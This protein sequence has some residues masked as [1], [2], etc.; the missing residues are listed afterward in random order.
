MKRLLTFLRTTNLL[1]ICCGLVVGCSYLHASDI[2]LLWDSSPTPDVTYRLYASTNGLASLT[3]AQVKVNTGTNCTVIIADMQ[4]AVWTFAAT[5]VKQTLSTNP[6]PLLVGQPSV[7]T[8][9]VESAPSN[10]L[11]LEMP[12]PPANTRTYILELEVTADLTSTNWARLGAFRIAIPK[13][14]TIE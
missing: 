3:N 6:V 13:P 1:L 8:N 14:P 12:S 5:A 7:T 4:P 10:F 2:H 11:L 9:T